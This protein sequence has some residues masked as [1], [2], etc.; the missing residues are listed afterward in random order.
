MTGWSFAVLDW[1]DRLQHGRTL[2][3][4]LPLD[5]RMA[6]Q[7]VNIFNKLHLPD[8][9][10]CPTLGEAAGEWQRDMVRAIFGSL[11]DGER[12]VGEVF[13]MVPKKNSKTT[14]GGAISVTALLM[15][16]RPRAE[17]IYVGPTQE[18]AEVAF[19]Q[20]VGMIEADA[21]LRQR[22]HVRDHN[23]TIV[24]LVTKAQ[25]KIKTFDLK[26]VTGSK[27]V[28]VLLDELHLMGVMR[29]ASRI[30]AQIRGGLL[31]NPE[32]CLVMIT[33][34]SDDAPT[35]VFRT[36]LEYAR[37]VR[38]GRITEGV[39]M[40]PVLYEFP[41]TIQRDEQ[42]PWAN[43]DLWH[44]VTP[45]N[46]RSI[47]VDRLIPQYTQ[48]VEKGEEDERIW[49]SQHLNI[50]VGMAR[51]GDQWAGAD[52]WMGAADDSITLEEIIKRCDVVTVGV[53]GGGLDDLLGLSVTGR[54]AISRDWLFWFKAWCQ[55]DVL[56]K[57]KKI[58]SR[59]EAFA[60]DCDLVIC[61]DDDMGRDFRE[62]VE[63]C[64][65]LLLAGLC[66][67]EDAI[68]LDP[69][70]V[71]EIVDLLVQAGFTMDQI[72]AVPQGYRLNS[73]IKGFERK[74]KDG[75]AWHN[76]SEMM[77]WVVGNAK[78]TLSGSA[79]VITKQAS[80]TAKIDPLIAGFNSYQFMARGP[81]PSTRGAMDDYFR[82]V[83]A[84]QATS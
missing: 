3:P 59:L 70:G 32:S 74:L 52:Y 54:D 56:K 61:D 8:V 69:V 31:P 21:F 51:A 47:T 35:G 63:I 6:T 5:D 77:N 4:N 24:D 11:V 76:G 29:A 25:L 53:D 49:A 41:E 26:V 79:T 58:A 2:L 64:E 17:L 57:R 14:G 13:W 55:K 9:P 34:Q 62:L 18:V 43:P 83:R 80:G 15:N 71:A 10:G 12:Q 48:A 7:A 40:L 33:T 60:A 1:W 36:E 81:E 39:R 66:P 30:L 22:F 75:T 23:K 16:Q 65:R 73:A 67:D 50:Q 19:R 38:D 37:G 78:A 28:F 68:G 20:A 42:K 27:P 82:S 46:G 45:N 84:G 44:L 72:K